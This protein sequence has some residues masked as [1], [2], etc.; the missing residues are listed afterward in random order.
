MFWKA[1][2]ETFSRKLTTE[3][4][5]SPEGP[6]TLNSR[7]GEWDIYFN[8]FWPL[9]AISGGSIL[10]KPYFAPSPLDAKGIETVR[11]DQCAWTVKVMDDVLS[12]MFT[13]RDANAARQCL[14]MDAIRFSIYLAK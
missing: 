8:R 13:M 4:T 10:L 12:R 3:E 11:R 9:S 14:E 6:G 7:R 5:T 1:S 2:S